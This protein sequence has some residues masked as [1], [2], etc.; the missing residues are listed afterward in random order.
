MSTTV[1]SEDDQFTLDTLILLLRASAE[2]ETPSLSLSTPFLPTRASVCSV[3]AD[4]RP[5]DTCEGTAIDA[6]IL[7]PTCLPSYLP[8]ILRRWHCNARWRS[9][10]RLPR[11][12]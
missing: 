4:G 9:M 7:H 8:T 3:R 11:T 1:K 5:Y 6:A 2:G 12:A 10:R